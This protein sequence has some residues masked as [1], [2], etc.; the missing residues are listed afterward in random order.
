MDDGF[1]FINVSHLRPLACSAILY[2]AYIALA[3]LR[4]CKYHN[5]AKLSNI[6][7]FFPI[8]GR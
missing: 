4:G 2:Y 8:H 7:H 1:E 3:T 6:F 5:S